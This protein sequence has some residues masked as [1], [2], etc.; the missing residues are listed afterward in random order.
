MNNTDAPFDISERKRL[1]MPMALLLSL[2]TGTAV[3]YAAWNSVRDKVESQGAAISAL[4]AEARTT[5]EI[6]I[7]IDENVKDLRRER[8]YFPSQP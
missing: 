6:L 1:S 3:G 2:L 8:R 4:E 7:R 5:R